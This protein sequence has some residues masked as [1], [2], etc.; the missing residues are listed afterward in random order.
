VAS[1]RQN[2]NDGN[3]LNTI[4]AAVLISCFLALLELCRR[5]AIW[6]EQ[7]EAF[8]DLYLMLPIDAGAGAASIIKNG[9]LSEMGD[10]QEWSSEFD[11][12]AVLEVLE[13]G[14]SLST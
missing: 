7:G 8:D 2:P 9:T 4:T 13:G 14:R 6:I 12:E 1:K 10:G 3:E 11:V 5:N